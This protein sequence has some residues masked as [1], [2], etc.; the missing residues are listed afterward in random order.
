MPASLILPVS[1][2]ARPGLLWRASLLLSYDSVRPRGAAGHKALAFKSL[3]LY[4]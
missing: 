1:V 3:F 4:G 2:T